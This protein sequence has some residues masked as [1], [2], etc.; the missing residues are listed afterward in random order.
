MLAAPVADYLIFI[1]KGVL[2]QRLT[3]LIQSALGWSS[4]DFSN[5]IDCLNQI[6]EHIEYGPNKDFITIVSAK[7]HRMERYAVR[8]NS[9]EH[10]TLHELSNE[11]LK[12]KHSILNGIREFHKKVYSKNGYCNAEMQK[13]MKDDAATAT[14][15]IQKLFTQ[16]I[17][18][19]LMSLSLI[20]FGYQA[21]QMTSG[22]GFLAEREVEYESFLKRF[23]KMSEK[24]RFAKQ[25]LNEKEQAEER[26]TMLMDRYSN[27]HYEES[28][29]KLRNYEY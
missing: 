24:L 20:M 1:G 25:S 16:L 29:E 12:G 14:T 17:K 7:F 9:I 26:Q 11:V 13:I 28:M 4:R 3:S 21:R 10:Q 8:M 27:R 6:R 2:S 22:S 15:K 23:Q 18:V 5:C 19:E